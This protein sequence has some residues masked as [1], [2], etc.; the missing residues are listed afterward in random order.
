MGRNDDADAK[1]LAK[2]LK[3]IAAEALER[4][5]PGDLENAQE[6]LDQLKELRDGK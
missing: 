5:A 6:A 3:G 4:D 2:T 1:A